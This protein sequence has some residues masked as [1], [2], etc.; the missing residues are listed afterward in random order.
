MHSKLNP[1]NKGVADRPGARGLLPEEDGSAGD[2][3]V[4]E[5]PLNPPAGDLK[6]CCTDKYLSQRIRRYMPDFFCHEKKPAVEIYGD[7]H[8]L[9]KDYDDYRDE[10]IK[11]K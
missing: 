10:Y 4:P 1:L 8:T 6:D 5:N 2:S 3:P 9:R 11:N 7:V